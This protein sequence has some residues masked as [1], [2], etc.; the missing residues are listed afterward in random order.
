MSATES[1]RRGSEQLLERLGQPDTISE[2]SL[3]AVIEVARRHEVEI[4]D[5]C[6]FGKPGIDGVCGRF[7]VEPKVAGLVIQD[8][9]NLPGWRCRLD[10]FPLG[11]T[12]PT[13]I[14]IDLAGGQLAR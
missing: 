10:V 12:D 2:E 1:K 14:N 11:I 9:I 4:L 8:L 6:Q 13:V 5:W 7:Q 3:K